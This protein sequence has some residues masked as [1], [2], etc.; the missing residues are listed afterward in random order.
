MSWNLIGIG[1]ITMPQANSPS[2]SNKQV[3]SLALALAL[4][5]EQED[6]DMRLIIE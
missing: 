6:D 2:A 3:S 5:P 1:G 4:A